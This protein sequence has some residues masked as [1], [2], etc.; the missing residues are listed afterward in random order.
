M[1]RIDQFR[2]QFNPRFFVVRILVNALVLL[3]VVG[4]TPIYF[5]DRTLLNWLFLTL[6]LGVLNAIL[7]PILQFLTLSLVFVTYGVVLILINT[8][9]LLALEWLVPQRIAVTGLFWAL[10]G[11]TLLGLISAFLESLLGL[12]IP[13]VP[14]SATELRQRLERRP[15]GFTNF[16][17]AS[18]NVLEEEEAVLAPAPVA[19]AAPAQSEA[20]PSGEDQPQGGEVINDDLE[21]K[22]DGEQ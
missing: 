13:I 14:E 7:R 22:K 12:S 17:L 18:A 6:L 10:V 16:I 2:K 21:P 15:A 1:K 11:G 9:L 8:G 3:I 19:P 4:L 5:V 20:P